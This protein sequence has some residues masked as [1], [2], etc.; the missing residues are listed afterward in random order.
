MN[1][2]NHIG[3]SDIYPF[4]IV[5]RVSDKTVEIRAMHAERDPEWKPEFVSGGFCGTVVN[6]N[7]QRWIITRNEQATPFRIRLGKKG[8]KDSGGARYQISDKPVMFH[9]Y[10]F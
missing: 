3:Y 9:D 10:N 6:Q 2:A 5:R 1:Y 7:Q 8:W 4:E